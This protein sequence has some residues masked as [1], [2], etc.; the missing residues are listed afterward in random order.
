MTNAIEV[1]DRELT[2]EETEAFLA[3][4]AAEQNEDTVFVAE[5]S[6]DHPVAA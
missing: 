2:P 1:T 4:I 3:S 5:D 6:S